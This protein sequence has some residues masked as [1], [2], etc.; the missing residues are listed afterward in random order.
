MAETTIHGI[1]F[2]IKGSADD[3]TKALDKLENTLR[4]LKGVTG[5]GL[6]AGAKGIS[7]SFRS[8]QKEANKT[9]SILSKFTK[10][11]GR[12]A[13]YRAIRG[14]LKS[15]TQA[16]KEGLQNAYQFSKI[17]G[18]ELASTMDRLASSSLK[19]KNQM[20]AA[21]GGLI[22]AIEP[23]VLQLIALVTRA[24]N[25]I[26]Q[27][28]AILGGKSTY[29]KAI[30]TV[31]EYGQ[32]I[33][34]AGAAAKEAMKYLA[35]FDELNVL[36]DD[37][38]GGGGGG[39]GVPDYSAMFE[40]TAVS[41][42]LQD[43]VT[44]FKITVSDVLFDWSDLTGEQI[45]EKVLAGLF[46]VVGLVTGLVLTGSFATG[47]TL[48]VVGVGL[49]LVADTFIF[50]HDGVLESSEIAHSLQYVL[51]G[52]AG[53][54]IGFTVGGVHGALIGASIG[55][56]FSVVAEALSLLPGGNIIDTSVLLDQLTTA[57]GALAGGVI[58]FT[59]GGP[60]G[61]LIGATIG[62]GIT[63]AITSLKFNKQEGALSGESG[64]TG[65]DYFIV[66]VLGLPSDD[67]WK[68][69]GENVWAKLQEGLESGWNSIKEGWKDFKEEL[70]NIFIKPIVDAFDEFATNHP[71]IAG[72][73]GIE[74]GSSDII[75]LGEQAGTTMWGIEVEAEVTDV[76][77]SVPQEKRTFKD[78]WADLWHTRDEIPEPDK[79]VQNVT[80]DITTQKD[81]V[82]NAKKLLRDEV[83]EFGSVDDTKLTLAQKV[84]NGIKAIFGGTDKTELKPEDTTIPSTAQLKTATNGMTG[85]KTPEI[86][87]IAQ[88]K[89][90]MNSLTGKKIPSIPSEADFTKK[91]TSNLNKTISNMEANITKKKTGGLNKTIGNMTGNITRKTT[92]ELNKV[93][94][95]TA[96]FT[97]RDT[98]S[99]NTVINCT[100]NITAKELAQ[101]LKRPDGTMSIYATAVIGSIAN[102]PNVNVNLPQAKGGAFYGGKWHDSPQYARGTLRAG[103]AFIAGEAGPEV[104]GHIGGRTEV[105][106]RSQLAATMYAAVSS[107]MAGLRFN[108]SSL[109]SP[110]ATESGYDEEAM[111]RAMLRALNDS[112]VADSEITL[113]GDVLY[114]KMVQRNRLNTRMTGVNAMSATA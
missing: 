95:T 87:S 28:M 40:E 62:L 86:P 34:G 75:G 33:G 21:F 97:H 31:T 41:Q 54:V 35:P 47:L 83:A 26:A 57:I 92:G 88:F 53:G 11:L 73:L 72:F 14:A 39:S 89:E 48:A 52:L 101:S 78:W 80:A 91:T 108:I 24:A 68:Q 49:G 96:N 25:A 32:A 6:G 8:M 30:D 16:F 66:D 2:Q 38:S 85:K 98:S 37:K 107:A 93:I 63:A 109:G 100:A 76:K 90:M 20:G 13:F 110:T 61:A 10:S 105:L 46:G 112:D 81:S 58:G 1:E 43:F 67:E 44:D 111:Y 27:L 94:D 99:L 5:N 23:V 4:R 9:S 102:L 7:N 15:V 113:D 18:Y 114:R 84:V 82:P 59:V 29:L 42:A 19:M 17:T 69:W 106:N 51:N 65:L 12:V 103:T 104:V 45:A 74:N 36:P 22:T 71:K 70:Y 56:G 60:A 77:D 3:A 55:I 50:D 79:T 64:R